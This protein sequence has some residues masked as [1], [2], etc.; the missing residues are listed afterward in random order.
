MESVLID[1][2]RNDNSKNVKIKENK[3]E[4]KRPSKKNVKEMILA[5]NVRNSEFSSGMI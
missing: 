4:M 3:K 2:I 5:I 1:S